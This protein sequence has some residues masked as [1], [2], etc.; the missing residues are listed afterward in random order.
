MT[1]D[2]QGFATAEKEH[3]HRVI[4]KADSVD[5]DSSQSALPPDNPF[6][7]E[8]SRQAR[9][10]PCHKKPMH[11]WP[12]YSIFITAWLCAFWFH[13]HPDPSKPYFEQAMKWHFFTGVASFFGGINHTIEQYYTSFTAWTAWANERLP[14]WMIDFQPGQIMVRC[15]FISMVGIL[16]TEYYTVTIFFGTW[17]NVYPW[18]K[19]YL[20]SVVALGILCNLLSDSYFSI[21]LVHFI[22]MTLG[23]SLAMWLGNYAVA[24][25]MALTLVSGT[26]WKLQE[27]CY[28][29]TPFDIHYNDI[30][31]LTSTFGQLFVHYVIVKT[32]YVDRI[33]ERAMAFQKSK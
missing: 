30:Y 20:A 7:S 13:L 3:G 24:V 2:A 6:E 21:V 32:E 8:K 28:M 19:Q 16:L 26:I 23:G 31:H 10:N 9:H 4:R 29:G 1:I 33:H 15:W 27:Q 18:L 5:N 14:D 12:N 17:T 25:G 22:S 11:L